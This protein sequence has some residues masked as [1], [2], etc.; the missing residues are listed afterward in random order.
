MHPQLKEQKSVH[1]PVQNFIKLTSTSE[2]MDVSSHHGK[3]QQLSAR[4]LVCLRSL[5]SRLDRPG[6]GKVSLFRLPHMQ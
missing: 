4:G 2:W 3:P 6:I 5:A 1:F